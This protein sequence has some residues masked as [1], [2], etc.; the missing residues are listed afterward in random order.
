MYS[1]LI[2][3]LLFDHHLLLF[4]I[5]VN[6]F[7]ELHAIIFGNCVG[8]S[9]IIISPASSRKIRNKTDVIFDLGGKFKTSAHHLHAI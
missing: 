9:F 5:M 3:V 7:F 6:I 2:E 8:Y 4:L 1:M